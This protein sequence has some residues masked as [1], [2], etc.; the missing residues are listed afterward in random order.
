M[1]IAL[2]ESANQMDRGTLS[3][4]IADLG[5]YLDRVQ[6]VAAAVPLAH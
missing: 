2:E 3:A 5:N 6:L 1:G 4:Q